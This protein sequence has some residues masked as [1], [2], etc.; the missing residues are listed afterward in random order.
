MAYLGRL[1]RLLP[2]N[3]QRTFQVTCN[4]LKKS[5][6]DCQRL[7]NACYA[8]VPDLTTLKW[9]P[10]TRALGA[11]AGID[12]YGQDKEGITITGTVLILLMGSSQGFRV[13]RTGVEGDGKNIP[14]LFSPLYFHVLCNVIC[15]SGHG[16]INSTFPTLNIGQPCDL[17]WPI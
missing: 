8:A 2:K 11:E 17:R 12:Q 9:V 13:V 5:D 1:T 16:E 6:G 10:I 7:L 3:N 14:F 15:S 4:M